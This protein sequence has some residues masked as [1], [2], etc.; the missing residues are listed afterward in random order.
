MLWGSVILP[1]GDRIRVL[2][3]TSPA[4]LQAGLKGQRPDAD[5]GMLFVYPKSQLSSFW[6]HGVDVP[7]DIIWISQGSRIT[8]IVHQARPCPGVPCPK[9]QSAIPAQYVLELQGGQASKHG[10]CVGQAVRL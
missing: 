4:E 2:I 9:Y 6:M 1:C 3:A 8:H 7:L 5:E 10:L